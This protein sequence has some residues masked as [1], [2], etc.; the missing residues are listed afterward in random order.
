LLFR[1]CGTSA[2]GILPDAG[3]STLS[4]G[5]NYPGYSPRVLTVLNIPSH[6]GTT[7]RN[8]R[9]DRMAGREKTTLRNMA[10]T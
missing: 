10:G 3:I 8:I 9:H 2:R 7:L 6:S 5:E 1:A 4:E